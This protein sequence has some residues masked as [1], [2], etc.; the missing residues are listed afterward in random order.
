MDYQIISKIFA[1]ILKK[2]LQNFIS[3]KQTACAV[4]R[5]V[6]EAERSIFDLLT[7]FEK[8]QGKKVF[9]DNRH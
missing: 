3:S 4:Q 9:S 6:D 7:V 8:R 1:S 2:V 5:C